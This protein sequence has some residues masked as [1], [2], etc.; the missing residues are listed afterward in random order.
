MRITPIDDMEKF[1]QIE[2]GWNRLLS[3]SA[4]HVPFL[5]HEFLTTWWT[6][7]GGGEWQEGELFIMA[8]HD[9]SQELQGIAPFFLHQRRVMFL[10]SYEIAD[11]LDL[12]APPN[13]LAP[14]S[15]ALFE[16]LEDHTADWDVI[17]LYNLRDNSPTLNILTETAK[18]RG[19]NMQEETLRPAPCLDLPD[20]WEG[21]LDGL[22]SKKAHEIERKLRRAEGYFL[23]VEWYQVREESHL[24]TEIES[25]LELMSY[26][27]EK[28]EFLTEVMETQLRKS[29]HKAFQAGWVHLSFLTVGGKKAASYLNFDFNNRIWLYNSGLNPM[30]E[31]ISPGWVLLSY[32]IRWAIEEGKDAFDFLRGAERYKYDFGGV[33]RD[34][35]RVQITP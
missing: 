9:D 32:L 14:F 21:Y 20:S 19:W 33:D 15:E 10:G 29:V 27:P 12:I 30:F 26:H 6:T 5:R 4:S 34:V 18:R 22:D 23:P 13:Q 17:D 3:I 28:A 2:D 31:N 24:E 1:K 35:I 25:F 8:G 7:L 16:H 11:Y